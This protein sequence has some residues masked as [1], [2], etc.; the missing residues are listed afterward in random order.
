MNMVGYHIPNKMSP[1][2]HVNYIVYTSKFNLLNIVN[3]NA[4]KYLCRILYS[5][6]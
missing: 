5:K 2:T 3:D 6:C 1:S 4:L